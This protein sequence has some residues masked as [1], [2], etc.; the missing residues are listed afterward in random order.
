MAGDDHGV[1]RECEHGVV[2][3]A[4]DFLHR[5]AGQVGASDGA[6]EES[7][8]G[9][10]FLVGGKIEADA[11]FRVSGR[12]Q[13]AGAER[14]RGDGFS[15]LDILID[16]DRARWGHADPVGLLVEHFQQSIVIL[17]QQ[18]GRSRGRAQLHGSADVVDVGMGDHD[19]LDLQIVLAD[20]G[21]HV[22]NI[23]AGIDH[24]GFARCVVA[25]DRAIALQRAHLDDF[26]DHNCVSAC[27]QIP[28]YDAKV[29]RRKILKGSFVRPGAL[30][31]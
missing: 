7:V 13:D 3:R 25:D 10:Q 31:G 17:V 14:A 5:S 30:R 1:I 11:A 16:N 23:V 26:V 2:Q 29:A 12:V 28:L 6:G 15:A 20:D 18:D 22:V 27:D 4:Q 9:D 21:Q 19:L 8:A 24:H